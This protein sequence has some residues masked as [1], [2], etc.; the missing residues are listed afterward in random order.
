MSQLSNA[1]LN[2]LQSTYKDD[3]DE[4]KNYYRILFRPSIAV[5]ARELNQL[6]TILQNQISRFA[7]HVFKDGAVVT[8]CS[9]IARNN[10]P[11]VRV[12]DN[13]ANNDGTFTSIADISFDYLITSNTDSTS[14]VRA[15]VLTSKSGFEANYPD[16][17]RLYLKYIYTGKDGSN[18]DVSTFANGDTL[19]IYSKDQ[20]SFGALSNTNLI[21]SIN[22]LTT[23]STATIAAGNGC[24]VAATDGII[25]QKGFF[26]T[27]SSQ[28]LV[29]ND[30]L[31]DAN[32]VKVGFETVETI[33]TEN[34]DLTLNDNAAGSTNYNAPGAHRLKLT[35]SLTYKAKDDSSNNLNF[36]AV[37]EF[38]GNTVVQAVNDDIY[39]AIGDAIKKRTYEESGD[40]TVSPH[41][42]ET[43]VNDANTSLFNYEVSAGISYVK[44]T[45]VELTGTRR[46]GTT[47]ANTTQ[48]VQNIALTTN[49][50]NYVYCKE[51]VGAMNFDKL[52]EV[53]LYDATQ[54]AITDREGASG[55]LSGN[56][57]GY[58][59]IKSV[60]FYS[61]TKGQPSAQYYVY[62]FNIRMNAGKNFQNDVKSIYSAG[63]GGYT[64]FKADLVLENSKAKIYDAT[65]TPMVFYTGLNAVKTL[66]PT[67]SSRD[68]TFY[69][70][71]TT[72]STLNS[73]GFMS[74]T[75]SGGLG[76]AGTEQLFD[77]DT[78]DI[79]VV[80]SANA[81]TA[82]GG[83]TVTMYSTVNSTASNTTATF[84]NG[85][86]TTFDTTFK[87]GDIIRVSNTVAGSA[88]TYVVGGI[89]SANLMYVSPA[90]TS[91]SV[92]NT[93]QRYF[94]DGTILPVTDSM[95]SVNA[96][97]NT[98]TVSTGLTFD[99]GAG[100]TVYAQYPVIK[101]S[102]A[103]SSV[104][105][106]KTIKRNTLLK[107]NCASHSATSIGPWSLGLPDV[108]KINAIYVGTGS[109][110]NSTPN[111]ASWFSLDSGQKDDQYDFA[112][113]SVLPAYKSNI[114]S[115]TT[116]L[117][118]VDHFI[119][120]T[121]SGI[122]YF[123][124]ESYPVSN[125][126]ISS[127][128]TTIALAEIPV[129]NSKT[130]GVRYD[131]RNCIDF[132]P[133]KTATANSISNTNPG[134]TFIT[135][136]PANS[137]P[138][139]WN[140][141]TYGQYHPEVDSVFM[142]DYEYYL[143]RYD[144]VLLG[145]SGGLSV[146]RGTP[147][148]NP[149][150]P[151]NISDAATVAE[152][153]VPAFPS[154][155]IREGD[156]YQRPDLTTK[157]VLRSNKRYTMKDIGVLEDR[158]SKLEY[159]T[160]LSTLEKSAKD[161]ALPDAT[162][163]DRFK[164]GIFADPFNNHSLGNPDAFGSEYR[165]SIDPAASVAR[166]DFV[167]HL[168]D[169]QYQSSYG[170][171]VTR[172]GPFVMLP[173]DHEVF[174]QQRFAT[175][176][177]LCAQSMYSFKGSAMLFP[178]QDAFKDEKTAPAI[179][180]TLDLAK[181]IQDLL[182]SGFI[183]TKIYG[184]QSSTS[185]VD[186]AISSVY[187]GGGTT[188][189]TDTTT[190][191]TTVK[192]FS[193]LSMQTSNK[194]YNLGTFVTD[195]S[196][197]SYMRAIDVAFYSSNLKPGTKIHAYFDG[198][199]VDTFCA[200]GELTVTVGSFTYDT[201]AKSVVT[202]NAP[203]GTPLV[204]NSSGCVAGIFSVPAQTFRTG[205]RKF[206]LT[207][208]DN[209]TTGADA[210]VTK[211]EA[212]FYAT[213]LAVTKQSS[214]LTTINPEIKT[215]Q[216]KE[217]N[218]TVE[219][220]HIV[221][222]VADP[223]VYD[224]T[225]AT[226]DGGS[227]C[228][229]PDAKVLM[230]DGS[231][232]RIADVVEGDVVI[233]ADGVSN[234]VE[235]IKQTVVAD[236]QMVSIKGYEFFVTD[237]HLFLTTNGWKTWR[238]DRLVDN[239]RNNAIFLEGANRYESLNAD[240][241]L[242]MIAADGSTNNVKYSDLEVTVHNFDKDYVVHDL[243]LKGDNTY[244][245][246]GF[247]VHNCG[248]DPIAQ[249][250]M[251]TIPTNLAGQFLSKVDLYF[252]AKDA[253]KGVTLFLCEMVNGIPDFS[254]VLGSCEKASSDVNISDDASAVTT[255]TFDH[256]I[257]TSAES[258]YAFVVEPGG[259]SPEYL[260]FTAKTGEFDI[261]TGEQ[262]YQN[263]YDGILFI[264]ANA[265]T[266]NSY[267]LEDIKFTLYRAKFNQTSGTAF[268]Y[269]ED[270]EYLSLTGVVKNDTRSISVG[271]VV[272]SSNA[273]VANTTSGAPFGIVQSYDE[274]TGKMILDSSVGG[275]SNT[276]GSERI[277]IHRIQPTSNTGLVYGGTSNT[278]VASANV[279][280]V[281][282]NKYHTITPKFATMV[283]QGTGLSLAYKGTTNSYSL[284]SNWV[285]IT[286]EAMNE[287]YDKERIVMSKSNELRYNT[288]GFTDFKSTQFQATLT[289][290]NPYVSP[291]IDLRRKSSYFIENLINNDT[292]NEQ[293]TYGNALSKYVSKTVIL[294]DGQDAEDLKVY[295]TGFRPVNSDIKVYA[296]VKSVDDPEDFNT[297]LWTPLS[298][299]NGGDLVYSSQN[300]V[301]D[302]VEYEFGIANGN[303]V[304]QSFNGNTA[305]TNSTD[306]ITFT[307]NSFANNQLVYYYTGTGTT[308]ITGLSNNTFYYV[309]NANSTSLKL[310]AS[311]GGA[312]IDISAISTV[313]PA[314]DVAHY[315]R[316][317]K[318]N[319]TGT[320]F[321][322]PDNNYVTEYYSGSSGRYSS[323]K[324]FAIKIVLTSSD[325][326]NYPRLNDLRAIALQK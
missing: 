133:V 304:I 245:V 272:Y 123:T 238:P 100:N 125:D 147:D 241:V 68:T 165:I 209:L 13:F 112:S 136:N 286:N 166:P 276:V 122:G 91:N 142:A 40:Y 143:P 159:Y 249:S 258:E 309:V 5:Q 179:N 323:Y 117:V 319:V 310:S 104:Q 3:Y 67:G 162:G 215:S 75:L 164:N 160:V 203:K 153:F 59:N 42:V 85:S 124:V 105:A 280:S 44:G 212:T 256:P 129:F 252:K 49:Y 2:I 150:K 288:S 47:R 9:I 219:K 84:V 93:Y 28:Y 236:R 1:T 232:K 312:N 228:F 269:N 50:G 74:F 106:A 240:D 139:T 279:A 302:Y 216:G 295:V 325:R 186:Q 321:L 265:K 204:A 73:N 226:G 17:N 128:S 182:S 18:N 266:W 8:G 277:Q 119:A 148:I 251:V 231:W 61:G 51:V 26:Q 185:V 259:R 55:G 318:P 43:T 322:N 316:G 60:V 326:V 284:D 196:Q 131:L 282:D 7:S 224:S 58:A 80:L 10:T 214:T 292:T 57:V 37:M 155:T 223:P 167:N 293:Y 168:I 324:Y 170:S 200:P 95:L 78:A 289:T 24:L 275:F 158:I 173:Y 111:Y 70:R 48:T 92:A 83:G 6:Q 262:V 64:P 283:P 177:R 56:I 38:D 233:G 82:N 79:Q 138:N 290:V 77:T 198:I 34:Q 234:I 199:S 250:F 305:V 94:P 303:S 194:E 31:P 184:S 227:C 285:S 149:K 206:L 103:T 255:F 248:G 116:L 120:D 297:K 69:Y 221:S 118:D 154:L 274:A 23:N 45:R 294:A 211:S 97:S 291:V 210:M 127:N 109:Y 53:K 300:K 190:T 207:N 178:S 115:S 191:T 271:D 32:S 151:L 247:V 189:T 229:D 99:V 107:I 27:V 246:D 171:N 264:S 208:V 90:V 220:S 308:P 152:V 102:G 29:I 130:S 181:P 270:D 76:A 313:S 314:I 281:D 12:L 140:I 87:V 298:Y 86:S 22:V 52:G 218:V 54:T 46:V 239:N 172:S 72:S 222:F 11:F 39:S 161:L 145:A 33:Y 89:L 137:N 197:L 278:L 187:G 141:S 144:L 243:H 244:V 195:V 98:F 110:S 287:M 174:A 225:S 19:F 267:Q 66:S 306:T 296:K 135:V 217:T 35:P 62:L 237:D 301:N 146:T 183:N 169:F 65:L 132:R 176:Y 21:A 201:P 205:E 126:G 30:Y 108:K 257:Y 4:T 36:F 254:K 315:L 88:A 261:K 134:N 213:G 101:G 163:K 81:Y 311:Q 175:N 230:A 202:T 242:V 192:D 20:D 260:I 307:T 273:T 263:P 188:T 193:Q 71:K 96:A 299:L 317:Y 63:T 253:T 121:S 320:A 113:I 156:T 25:Y 157:I 41:N 180:N 16:T 268:L 114:T 14:A 15:K 235:S